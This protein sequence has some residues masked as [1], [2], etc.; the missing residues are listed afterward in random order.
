MLFCPLGALVELHLTF[1]LR[2]ECFRHI[3][4]FFLKCPVAIQHTF[5]FLLEREISFYVNRLRA[6]GFYQR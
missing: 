4:F 1:S 6:F 3:D 5:S 2:F